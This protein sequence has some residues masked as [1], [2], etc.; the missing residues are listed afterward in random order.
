MVVGV[1][2]SVP[3]KGMDELTG[4]HVK[5]IG[6]NEHCSFASLGMAVPR[7]LFLCGWETVPFNDLY[8]EVKSHGGRVFLLNDQ[9]YQLSFRGL[10]RAMLFRVSKRR[11]YAGVLVP[12]ES[13]R[14]LMRLYGFSDNQIATGLYSADE[15]MFADGEPILS[16]EKR[17]VYVGQFCERKNVKRLVE[18]FLKAKAKGEGEQR[19]ELHLYGSGPLKDELAG[20]VSASR[21]GRDGTVEIH[22]FLQPEVLAAVYR[23]ARVLALPSLEEHWGLVVHEGALSGCLLFL[24]DRIGAADD[25]LS[26]ANGIVFKPKLHDMKQAFER[27]FAMSDADWGMAHD[28]SLS[29][30]HKIGLSSFTAGVR[31]LLDLT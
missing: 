27:L 29:R 23:K 2:P 4:C 13:G 6:L 7:V 20:L 11:R 30:A 24:S 31:K 9:N 19:W 25:L 12:G 22:D 8:R 21:G 1:P 28:Q 17:I 18:A 10:V 14:R 16:R 5:W 15:T 3:V 26:D